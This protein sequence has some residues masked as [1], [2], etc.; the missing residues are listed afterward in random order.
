[1]YYECLSQ[2]ILVKKINFA[3]F[4]T[5]KAILVLK[6][7]ILILKSTVG[8]T[9]RVKALIFLRT[10]NN[11]I[12][13]W[14]AVVSHHKKLIFISIVFRFSLKAIEANIKQININANWQQINGKVE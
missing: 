13:S 3:D 6:R 4:G 1:M 14:Q 7:P 9:F 11:L 2:F 5:K 10:T 12:V 8:S